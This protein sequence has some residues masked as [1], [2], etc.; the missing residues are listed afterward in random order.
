MT[1]EKL[2][3]R[4][5]KELAE[6]AKKKQVTGW[7][8]M[9]K[10]ELIEALLEIHADRKKTRSKSLNPNLKRPRNQANHDDDWLLK[11]LTN[12]GF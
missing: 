1:F 5:R 6:M 10:D 11:A 8:G 2:K 4:T 3:V 7:H 12:V 9:K